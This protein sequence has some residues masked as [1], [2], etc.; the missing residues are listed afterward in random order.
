MGKAS[1]RTSRPALHKS[2]VSVLLYTAA[3]LSSALSLLRLSLCLFSSTT[4]TTEKAILLNILK[5]VEKYFS[6]LIPLSVLAVKT[7]EG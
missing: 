7:V 3:A 6:R 4:N 2:K 5:K 1:W